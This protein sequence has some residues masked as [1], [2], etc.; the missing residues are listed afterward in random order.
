MIFGK[1]ENNTTLEDV[2][3]SNWRILH[4]GVG[5]VRHP[6]H[7]AV[8]TTVEG[9]KPQ[10]RTVIL[11]GFSEEDRILICHCDARS[12]KVTQIRENPNVS[13]LF[14]HPKKWLQLRLSGTATIHTDDKTA[15]SQWEKVKLPNRINYSTAYPPGSPTENPG[16]GLADLQRDKASTLLDHPDARKNFA[17]IVCRFDDLDWLLL[18]LTGNIRAKFHWEDNRMEASWIIP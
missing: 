6:F 18:K 5:N 15:E 9:H 1:S 8:L 12:P 14:Y 11:R 2:L 16:S 10:L 7:Q 4:K 3:D 17:V 13:C